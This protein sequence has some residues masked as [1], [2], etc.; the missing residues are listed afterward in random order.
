M[1][2]EW[3]TAMII[4]MIGLIKIIIIITQACRDMV[5]EWDTPM[6]IFLFSYLLLHVTCYKI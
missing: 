6:I 1:V 4:I 3:D 5:K 2:K